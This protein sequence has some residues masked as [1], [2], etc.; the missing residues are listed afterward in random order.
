MPT[1][2]QLMLP[3]KGRFPFDSGS[4]PGFFLKSSQIQKIEWLGKAVSQKVLGTNF[5]VSILEYFEQSPTCF[6][7]NFS[8]GF[9]VLLIKKKGMKCHT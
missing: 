6:H 9:T 8:W 7:E 1:I 5:Y 2:I 3:Q 4:S